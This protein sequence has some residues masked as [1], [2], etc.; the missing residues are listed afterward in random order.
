MMGYRR[1]T[2]P[3]GEELHP[4]GLDKSYLHGRISSSRSALFQGS[5]L[6][7]Q[8]AGFTNEIVVLDDL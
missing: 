8:Q 3:A 4:C 5:A 7:P 2:R 1:T 6:F